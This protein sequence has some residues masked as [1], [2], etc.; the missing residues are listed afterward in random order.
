MLENYAKLLIGLNEYITWLK[1]Q[2]ARCD[3]LIAEY[4]IAMNNCSSG[5]RKWEYYDERLVVLSASKTELE[6]AL[7]VLLSKLDDTEE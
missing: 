7:T 2:I 1:D 5:S 3:T 4:I 6:I